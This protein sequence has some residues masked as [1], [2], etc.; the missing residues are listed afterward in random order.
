MPLLIT[1][2]PVHEVQADMIIYIRAKEHSDTVAKESLLNKCIRAIRGATAERRARS[3]EYEEET[4]FSVS[5]KEYEKALK[6]AVRHGWKH[7]AVSCEGEIAFELAVEA[8]KVFLQEHDLHISLCFPQQL[9][10]PASMLSNALALIPYLDDSPHLTQRPNPEYEYLFSDSYDKLWISSN[11]EEDYDT[12]WQD[13]ED[14]CASIGIFDKD[15]CPPQALPRE[16][17]LQ[18]QDLYREEA[19]APRPEEPRPQAAKPKPQSG[20]CAIQEFLK[21]NDAGFKDTL[22]KY[23]DRTGKK[24][25]EVYK[26]A[27]VDR[28]LFSKIMNVQGYNPSKPTAIAF[29]IALELNLEET[30]DLIGRA[31][32]TLSHASTF[33]RIIEFFILEG[34]YDIY[35]INEAL[36]YFDQSLL[37]C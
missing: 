25:S 3:V 34:N 12:S 20:F 5:G 22:L 9:N 2:K 19:E 16:Y 13:E 1:K 33:D 29:A 23:I 14:R 7:V 36:F 28:R 17:L 10:Y 6:R 37:G 15:P 24:D 8:G 32:Y 26:K 11:T 27:N 35:E 31:G 30:K 4:A 21:K 18:S